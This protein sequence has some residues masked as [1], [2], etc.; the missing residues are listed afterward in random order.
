MAMMMMIDDAADDDYDH[1]MINKSGN[2]N[3]YGV[4]E[5]SC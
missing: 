2:M 3:C 5:E 4:Y 1:V